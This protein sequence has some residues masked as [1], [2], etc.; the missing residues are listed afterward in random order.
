MKDNVIINFSRFPFCF[1]CIQVKKYGFT[2]YLKDNI[3]FFDKFKELNEHIIP[4]FVNQNFEVLSQGRHAHPIRNSDKEYLVIKEILKKLCMDYNNYTKDE[5]FELWFEQN[6]NDYQIWQLGN[7]GGIRLF[8]IRN[9]NVF[10]VLFIDYHHLL[11]ASQK[12][13]QINYANYNFC[14]ITNYEK[15]RVR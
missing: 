15:E 8:G 9:M 14:P 3:D 1:R 11:Y 4:S 12:H 5:E 2:N 13:N 7:I 10:N 6:I